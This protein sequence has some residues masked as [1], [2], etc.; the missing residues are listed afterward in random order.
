MVGA[1]AVYAAHR[2]ESGKMVIIKRLANEPYSATTDT[3]DIR[4]IA[5]KEKCVPKQWI[6]KDGTYVTKE[7]EDYVRPLIIGELTPFMVD[8]LP[9]HLF[10]GD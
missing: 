6:T 10:I 7:M 3:F 2:G 8:G 1:D 4:E 9:R 5:N